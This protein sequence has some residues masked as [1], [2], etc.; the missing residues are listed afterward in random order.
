MATLRNKKK[1]AALNKENCEEHRRISLAQNSNGPRS[2]DDYITQLLKKIEGRVT[3]KLSQEF[4]TTKNLRLGALSRLDDS[5]INPLI[6]GHSGNAPDTSRNAYGTNQGT[7]EDDSQSDLQGD[8]GV[9][10]SQTTQ[11]SGPEEDHDRWYDHDG[12]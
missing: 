7:N 12:S 10:Q 2:Q 5:L 3:E 8:A 6:Q 1:L 9:V 11:I 4:K